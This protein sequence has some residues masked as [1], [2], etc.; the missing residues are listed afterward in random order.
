MT[1]VAR[2]LTRTRA[3]LEGYPRQ[4]WVLFWGMLVNAAGVTLVWPF[5]TIYLRERLE[6][7]LTTVTLVMTVGSVAGLAA[8]SVVG[9]LVDRFGRRGPMV[10]GLVGGSA[11]RAA[12]PLAGSLPVWI[13]LMAL[14]GALGP[15]YQVGADAMIADLIPAERRPNAY[16]LL[17]TISNLGYTVGPAIGGF[18]ATASYTLAFLMAAG[19]TA[20]YALMIL[21]LAHETIPRSRPAASQVRAEGTL[22][23]EIEGGYGPV[24]R[25]RRFLAFCGLYALTGIAPWSVMML[26]PVYAK[27]QFGVPESQSGFFISTNAAMVVLFQYAVTLRAKRHAPGPV[28][29]V[30]ALLFGLGAGSVVLGGGFWPFWASM[31]VLTLGELVTL[32]TGMALAARLAP[33][34]MRGRYLGLFS[35]SWAIAGGLG[36]VLGG[37]LSDRIA[38][39]ATWYGGLAAGVMGAAGY[40]LLSGRLKEG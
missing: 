21:V 3:A 14:Q 37:V 36:P 16:A 10:V 4:F 40:V 33:A 7:P 13:G 26:L 2:A 35:L 23:P 11:V 19:A 28:L 32:P 29:A 8:V 15:L 22:N 39:A 1:M 25:D 27:E 34:E 30:G 17:R 24:L 20:I 9:P 31:V 38:P 12:M 5:M 6:V 18:V